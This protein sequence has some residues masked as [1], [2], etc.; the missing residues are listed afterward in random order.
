MPTIAD[1]CTLVPAVFY[2][3]FTI[4]ARIAKIL[5]QGNYFHHYFLTASQEIPQYLFNQSLN[6]DGIILQ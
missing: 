2:I 3:Y 5:L 6:F 1:K 4:Q